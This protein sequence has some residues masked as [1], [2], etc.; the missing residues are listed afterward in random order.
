MPAACS[1]FRPDI[2]GDDRRLVRGRGHFRLGPRTL[3]VGGNGLSTNVTGVIADG[4]AG[5][6][7]GGALVK[8]GTGML[9]LSGIN[10]YTGTTMVDAGT[11]VVNGSIAASSGVTVNNGGFWRAPAP[12]AIRPSTAAALLRRAMAPRARRCP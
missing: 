2:R 5:G 11:L 8:T 9:T 1:T 7:T 4:G 10:T 12:S 6:G 3:T